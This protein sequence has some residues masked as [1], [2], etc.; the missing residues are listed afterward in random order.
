LITYYAAVCAQQP[1]VAAKELNW[2][3]L[4][5]LSAL[6][7]SSHKRLP[8]GRNECL[9]TYNTYTVKHF[10]IECV[11]FAGNGAF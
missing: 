6:I 11:N 7:I 8:V 5:V 4:P 2:T 1:E 9:T 3:E 10:L